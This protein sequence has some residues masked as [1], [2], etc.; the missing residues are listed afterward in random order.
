MNTYGEL[1]NVNLMQSYGF[2]EV[3]NPY[4]EVSVCM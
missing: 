4:D 2:A 1:S 3:D